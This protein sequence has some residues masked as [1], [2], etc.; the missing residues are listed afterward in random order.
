LEYTLQGANTKGFARIVTHANEVNVVLLGGVIG[1]LLRLSSK[2]RVDPE[3]G[4][5]R[6]E[7]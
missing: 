2:E 6:D 1:F 4:A 5:L 7:R 3:G